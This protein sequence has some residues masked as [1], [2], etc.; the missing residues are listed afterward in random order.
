MTSY[1][2]MA[3]RWSWLDNGLL[4]LLLAL[5]RFCWLWPWLG[6]IRYILTPSY[7]NPLL[8]PTLLIGVPVLS[9]LLARWTAEPEVQPETIKD[10]RTPQISVMARMGIALLGFGVILI[11]LW[12]Q[13]YH[14]DYALWD[15][16]WVKA[17]GL[18]LIHGPDNELAPAIP[19]ALTL[20][21]LWLRGMLDAVKT[22]GHDDVWGTFVIGI[23]LLVLYLVV[24][25]M[26]DL[27]IPAGS[28]NLIVLFFGVGMAALAFSSIKITTGLDRALGLGQRRATR[29]PKLSR[30]WLISVL[31][32]VVVLLGLGVG[33]G[34][35]LAPDQVA[36]L[37][38]LVTWVIGKLWNLIALVILVFGYVFVVIA[39]VLSFILQPLF[40]WLLGLFATKQQRQLLQPPSPPPDLP[41]MTTTTATVPD[42]YR[43]IALGVF[44]LVVIVIFALVLRRLRAAQSEEFDEERESILSAD[45][46]QD[47]LAKLFQKLFGRLRNAAAPNPFLSLADEHD[48]R[49]VIRNAYQNF[50]AAATD[51]GQARNR[52][53]TPREY[54]QQLTQ[55]LPEAASLLATLTEHYDYAR[56]AVEPPAPE[57]ATAAQQA[58]DQTQQII[59]NK[60]Q[61]SE[62]K[63]DT[64]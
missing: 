8:S 14:S 29:S 24:M 10:V 28:I 3:R 23:A 32:T 17:L 6:L 43:W 54:Q 13:L 22:L 64:D 58:W 46:L 49:R 41:S 59:E 39:Y 12:W 7:A 1:H 2:P 50:L 19:M 52:S 57:M 16:T 61:T 62:E 33:L 40:R 25:T 47:Q 36:V 55:E 27:P 26:I 60:R 44:V 5:L 42:V 21:Y 11:A 63:K 51:L 48:T 38:G 18:S 15:W 35:I 34:L 45:L 53:Q 30:Y 20:I 9:L 37:L 31:T 56:Y 4:P